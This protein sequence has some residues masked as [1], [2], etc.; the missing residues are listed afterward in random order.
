[1]TVQVA[2]K[3]SLLT[4]V[5][6]ACS[7]MGL[8]APTSV[9]GNLDQQIVQFLALATREGREQ[10]QMGTTIGGWQALRQ[11]YT[12]AVQSSGI[13]LGCSITAN[14]NIVTVPAGNNIALGWVVSNSGA[15]NASG[16]VYPTTV[17]QIID[18]THVQVSNASTVTNTNIS[19]AF[20]KDTY[21]MPAD[22][23]HM[24]PQ[25]QW[26]RGFRWQLLGPMSPQE[27]QVL[28]SGL[29]PTGPRRRYRLMGG[30]FVVDPVPYDTNT[31]VFEYY[32]NSWVQS[33]AGAAQHAWA[34]DTDFFVLDDDAL[35]LGL[36]WRFR[37][38]KG[39]DYDEEKDAWEQRIELVK[40]RQAG[41]RTL[42]LNATAGG[43]RLLNNQ[44]VP[45]T[46]FGS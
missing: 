32:C 27:W 30:N 1:M 24:I 34:A 22:Y 35:V 8:V 39:L 11:E 17:T 40:A 26:D 45:D 29:S 6:R 28:K 41:A 25:T 36:I 12:F 19:L 13:L 33:A 44:N 21:P 2:S 42:P 9:I 37:R 46:G 3:E 38:A 43:V 7:E 16:F 5:G 23:D 14:S 20:G 31:L 4:L 18:A 10:F 15:S